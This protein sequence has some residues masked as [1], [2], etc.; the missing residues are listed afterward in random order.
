MARPQ[1]KNLLIEPRP[2]DLT[3]AEGTVVTELGLVPVAWKRE[4][5]AFT[6]AFSVPP[7]ATATLRVPPPG[8][9]PQLSLNG[10]PAVARPTG[11][12]LELD[13]SA[14]KHIGVVTSTP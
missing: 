3:H 11:R 10:K 13:V 5:A 8:P 12:Y 4:A 9:N 14:G 2:G 6:I 1:K 7:G